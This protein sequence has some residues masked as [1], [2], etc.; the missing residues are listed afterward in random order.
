M[1]SSKLIMRLF[2][3]DKNTNLNEVKKT[4]LD[5]SFSEPLFISKRDME[6][7]ITMSVA[8]KNFYY[9]W[10]KDRIKLENIVLSEKENNAIEVQVLEAY[11]D[12][13]Y[14]KRKKKNAQGMILPKK[15]RVNDATIRVIFFEVGGSIY[16][17]IFSSN[18]SHIDRVQKLIGQN[19][20]K[21]VDKKYQI[22]PDLFNWLFY[23]YSLF[24]GE[25]SAECKLNN[26][27]GFIG[28][29][30]DE[31]NIFKSSSDQ[32]SE[33]II[34][35][36]F[37]SNGEILKNVT[38]RIT[39]AEGEFVFSID[40]KSNIT[41]F[42]NQ[43]MMYFNSSNLEL[44]IPVYLYS[45]LIPYMQKTYKESSTNFLNKEKNKF[46][47]KIGLEVI[48]S[49]IDNNGILLEDIKSLYNDS[50]ELSTTEIGFRD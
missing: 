48:N 39:S 37:I 15:D 3:L 50:D 29:S 9:T 35:K 11:A 28:N 23:K 21:E 47:I 8:E 20:I 18:E 43:S 2:L 19:I 46:S 31:H 26:I 34:T 17:L 1:A 40:H 42:L 36:A 12:L 27:S 13:E 38:V 22:E 25:L 10:D 6:Q 33:L 24:K 16:L 7:A 4:I 45:V 14:P 49:I 41:L 30:V 5:R 32:T 44:V